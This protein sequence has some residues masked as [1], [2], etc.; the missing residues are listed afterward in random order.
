MTSATAAQSSTYSSALRLGAEIS[1]PLS[2]A[3]ATPL[4]IAGCGIRRASI[5]LK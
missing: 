2:F 5:C 3:G 1:G 4:F